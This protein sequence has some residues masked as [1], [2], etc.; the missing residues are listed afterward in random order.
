M[1]NIFILVALY[2][3]INLIL[4]Q[5]YQRLAKKINLYDKPDNKLKK[6]IKKVPILGG[7]IL[8]INFLIILPVSILIF[9]FL[10]FDKKR[11]IFSLF[12]LII[13][14]FLIG[15][16]DDKIKMSSNMRIFLGIF[17]LL[18]SISLNNDLLIQI[19]QFSFYEKRIYLENISYIFTIFAFLAF[20]HAINMFD[21]LNAQ[22]LLYFIIINTFLFIISSFNIFYFSLY[23][24]LI[25][26]LILNYNSR[27]FLGDGGSYLLAALYAYLIIYEFNITK[28]I[29]FSDHILIL[30]IIPGLELLRLS[31]IRL[32]NGKNI[33]DGD[34]NHIHHILK[35]NHGL[36]N[37]NVI[38]LSLVL[39][40]IL[41]LYANINSFIIIFL[42]ILSYFILIFYN[43]KFK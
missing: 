35:K 27:V 25:S 12:F 5:N 39:T 24:P 33:F 30:M 23:F 11:E 14:F 15:F 29:S 2:F 10:I 4:L 13:S 6:H 34:L 22:V 18:I 43:K 37:T 1:N 20:I 21:G 40:P 26:I 28:N 7:I 8:L 42:T 32:I 41:L 3:F 31:F 9:D 19:L 36:F 16:F 38:V 17:V